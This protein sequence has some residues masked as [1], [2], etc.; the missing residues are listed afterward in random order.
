MFVGE[1]I[2][3]CQEYANQ[4][5]GDISMHVRASVGSGYIRITGVDATAQAAWFNAIPEALWIAT[6][7]TGLPTYWH[8]PAAGVDIM[9]QIRHEFDPNGR[10]NSQRFVV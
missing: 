3:R 8:T 9:Q 1:L 6:T 5:G 4:H 2:Q 7:A 10:L